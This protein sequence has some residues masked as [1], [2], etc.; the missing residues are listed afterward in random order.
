MGIE[1]SDPEAAI[2]EVR[3]LQ[4]SLRDQSKAKS[5][6]REPKCK[7]LQALLCL[8]RGYVGTRVQTGHIPDSLDREHS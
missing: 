1:F 3:H 7:R 4:T 6:N 5:T 2:P 8:S